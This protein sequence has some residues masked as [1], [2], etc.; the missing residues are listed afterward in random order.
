MLKIRIYLSILIVMP[1]INACTYYSDQLRS[2]DSERERVG[3][4]VVSHGGN[5][6]FNEMGI[7]DVTVQIFSYD[8]NS[9]LYRSILWNSE[10]W[11]R[12][13][14]YG[15]A[16]KNLGKYAFEYERIGGID[17]YPASKRKLTKELKKI[18][19]Q[20]ENSEKF[21]FV[22]DN[23]TWISPE[24]NEIA[25]PRRLYN[26]GV[27]SGST[28]RFCDDDWGRCKLDRYD[29]DGPVERLLAVDVDR[30]IMIDLTTAGARFS[31]TYDTYRIAKSLIE[32]HNEENSDNV[33]IEWVNDPKRAM[34]AS[35]PIADNPWSRSS[36]PPS[37][38]PIIDIDNFPNPVIADSRLAAFQLDGIEKKFKD[39]IAMSQTAVLMLNHGIFPGNEVYDPKINDT[40]ILNRNIKE[41]L[42]DKYP[43][44]KS[45]NI[46]G[47]WFGDLIINESIQGRSKLERSREMR[48]ENLGY[49]RLLDQKEGP[50]G[51]MK[52]R[53]WEALEE[54]K[55][56]DVNHIVIVFPQIMENSVLNLVEVPNQIAKEI[57]YK[58]W[59]DF[60]GYDFETYPKIG[61]PF[62]DYWG[63]WVNTSCKNIDDPNITEPCCLNMGGCGGDQ[64]Y[65]PL[66]QVGLTEKLDDLDP[67]LGYDVSA[68]GHLG[69]DPDLGLPNDDF[70]VQD[71]YTGSW[72]MWDVNEDHRA[73]A[74]FLADKVIEHIEFNSKESDR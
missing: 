25:H 70:P 3:V 56:N 9:P 10:F 27:E 22:V 30:I 62:A 54:L 16:Q 39:E 59:L 38:N 46:I 50:G 47:G 31:K 14:N 41:M 15:N 23:M 4:L 67:S 24:I 49:I 64:P 44:M 45:E 8:E 17:P 18:L 42:L 40:L 73:V 33:V 48:G 34:D 28:L 26:P 13:L 52:Y 12:L 51:D 68:Y 29:V 21:D 36:G 63:V 60:D 37:S 32:E 65:P 2:N 69:Y 71:Q 11:P 53:Y 20:M 74:Q 7:W 35:Y 61:H 19:N 5:E 1:L 43:T 55:N 57:G 6:V 66:R 58:G 72:A